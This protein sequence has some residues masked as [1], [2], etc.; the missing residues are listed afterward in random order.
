MLAHFTSQTKFLQKTNRTY[1]RC[2]T[3]PHKATYSHVTELSSWRIV[4]VSS[5]IWR[6]VVR[7]KSTGGRLRV[8]ARVCV[9]VGQGQ[10]V[11]GCLLYSLPAEGVWPV[12]VRPLLSLKWRPHFLNTQRSW[13]EKYGHGPRRDS[14]PIIT[15]LTRTS[16]NLTDRPKVNRPFGRTCGQSIQAPFAICFILV[17]CFAYSST[18]KMEATCSP[19]K[20]VEPQ[21]TTR[22][23]IPHDRTLH[24]HGLEHLISHN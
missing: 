20:S 4:R 17:S 5:G 19:D 14:K 8:R 23:Y 24:N 1:P 2:L 16:R 11:S 18:L 9:R 12:V 6:R 13:K 10:L 7:W 3:A 21:R 15:V 22:C